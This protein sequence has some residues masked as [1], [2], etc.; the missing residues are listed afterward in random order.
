MPKQISDADLIA[1]MRAAA[2]EDGVLGVERYKKEGSHSVQTLRDHFGSMKQA[3]QLAGLKTLR[4]QK[5]ITTA[6]LIESLETAAADT[7]EPVTIAELVAHDATYDM[8]TYYDRIDELAAE[9]DVDVDATVGGLPAVIEA[10][11]D[12]EMRSKGR[13]KYTDEH[14]EEAVR[15]IYNNIDGRL[16]AK[17][18]NQ[19]KQKDTPIAIPS[20]PT[21]YNK[22]MDTHADIDSLKDVQ[23]A[24]TGEEVS[25]SEYQE[26]TVSRDDMIADAQRV[27]EQTAGDTLTLG[28]YEEHGKYSNIYSNFDSI[29]EFRA[30]A[31]IPQPDQKLE[32]TDTELCEDIHRVAEMS[33]RD[34]LTASEYDEHGE[35]SI[36]TLTNHF[37]SFADA[38][39]EAGVEHNSGYTSYTRDELV[40]ELA[41]VVDAIDGDVPTRDDIAAH[42][43]VNYATFYRRFDQIQ[44]VSD[45]E[46]V[47]LEEDI[48]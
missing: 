24:A 19:F 11:T 20:Q 36:Q 26:C 3:H 28:Q 44:S 12:I 18:F 33:E 37:G 30:A 39:S 45:I 7:G 29:S 14:I 22:Y 5:R 9:S 38:C 43:D 23:E 13:V 25:D 47:L 6:A 40:A 21:V 17:H 10:V 35:A 16:K 32:Y 41:T 31:D 15:Y 27:T 46:T 2:D 1:D 4:E 8:S 34:G 48:I 42:T